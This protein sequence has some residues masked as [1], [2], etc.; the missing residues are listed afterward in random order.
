MPALTDFSLLRFPLKQEELHTIVKSALRA[1][2]YMAAVLV[3]AALLVFDISTD[4]MG[5][6]SCKKP[7]PRCQKKLKVV[8]IGNV[9]ADLHFDVS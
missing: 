9:F 1:E 7:E 5:A 2:D 3:R 6:P 4:E 8:L